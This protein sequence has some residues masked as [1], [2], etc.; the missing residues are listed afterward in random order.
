MRQF[1][2]HLGLIAVIY[3]TYKLLLALSVFAFLPEFVKVSHEGYKD[4]GK[5]NII[6]IGASNL[7]YNYDY[8]MLRKGLNAYN[9][10]SFNNSA[11]KG[12]FFILDELAHLNLRERDIMVFCLPHSF[13]E[14]EEYLP[15]KHLI[16]SDVIPKK[17]VLNALKANLL[18]SLKS[19]LEIS[20]MDVIELYQPVPS[21][22]EVVDLD[23]SRN[24]LTSH[25]N[26]S[27]FEACWSSDEN[28]FTIKSQ[29]FEPDYIHSFCNYIYSNFPCKV[30]FRFPPVRE[31]DFNINKERLEYLESSHQFLN[32][33]TESIYTTELFFDQWYHLNKCGR[34]ESTKKMIKELKDYLR[35]DSPH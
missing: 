9:I 6:L 3:L 31:D 1:L 19:F 30:V 13:Y 14:S 22:A 10:T 15:L 5:P 16:S 26:D 8:Q 18:L 20:I 2:K 17:T 25:H 7:Y 4:N 33:F 12:G 24:K 21:A 29:H 32:K 11:S 34:E 23:A 28:N 35:L 27:L